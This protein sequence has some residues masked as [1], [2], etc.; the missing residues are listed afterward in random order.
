[1]ILIVGALHR[2]P[3]P[4]GL[5]PLSTHNPLLLSSA[6]ACSL[7]QRTEMHRTPASVTGGAGRDAR[8][9]VACSSAPLPAGTQPSARLVVQAH[10]VAFPLTWPPRSCAEQ[11]HTKRDPDCEA[12]RAGRKASRGPVAS[13]RAAS[14]RVI[15]ACIL[16]AWPPCHPRPAPGKAHMSTLRHAAA[17]PM[18]AHGKAAFR[19]MPIAG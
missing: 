15:A 1:M 10:T 4:S 2:S 18:V 12:T 16:G 3:R 9:L 6:S 14:M 11:G 8:H 17:T 13:H 19:Q 5:Q 7:W